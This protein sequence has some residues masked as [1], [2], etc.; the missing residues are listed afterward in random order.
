MMN[1]A[2][3]TAV[4]FLLAH[5]VVETC[6]AHNRFWSHN[7]TLWHYMVGTTSAVEFPMEEEYLVD[8]LKAFYEMRNMTKQNWMEHVRI[9]GTNNAGFESVTTTQSENKTINHLPAIEYKINDPIQKS[10]VVDLLSKLPGVTPC[11]PRSV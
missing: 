4:V 9:A 8:G 5:W 11:L 3:W 2:R 1:L 6:L 7:H 10:G